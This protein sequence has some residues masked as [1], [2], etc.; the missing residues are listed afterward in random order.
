MMA[1]KVGC[2]LE[3]SSLHAQ[4]LTDRSRFKGETLQRR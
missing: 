1:D 4:P 3:L 2:K